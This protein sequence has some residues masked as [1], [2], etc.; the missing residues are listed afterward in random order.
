MEPSMRVNKPAPSLP[1]AALPLFLTVAL[2][3]WPAPAS[4]QVVRHAVP[5]TDSARLAAVL[6][7]LRRAIGATGASAAVIL[8]DGGV[9]S[10]ASGDAWPGA[11]A[12]PQTV[13]DVGSITKSYTAAL[14]L[15]LAADDKLRLDDSVARWLPDFSAPGVTIRHLLQHTSGI[16]DYAANPAFIPAIRA[17]IAAPWSP[18]DNLQF[19]GSTRTPPDSVWRYSNTNYV[20]LGI[21]AGKAGGGLY[22]QLLTRYVLDPLSLRETF[23]AGEDSITAERAH[24]F[25]DFSGDGKADD[26]SALVPDPA[27]TRG[28]GGAG[29]IVATAQDVARFA[30]A[31][32][33]GS[34]LGDA[35]HRD[36][37]RWRDRGDGW[38]YGLGVIGNPRSTDLLLGHLGNTTGVSAG[39][40][41]SRD[42]RITAVLL[43]NVHG[44]RMAAPALALLDAAV[45]VKR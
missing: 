5:A 21:I 4:P 24:A 44:V 43:A 35:V 23:V 7:S 39:V 12:T 42:R 9:W 38:Q 18:E 36:V 25:V 45:V 34:F 10:G 29:A 20:L 6:D 14:V 27:T 26:L 13:F 1:A 17:R 22:S 15:R 16:P 2:S 32:F 28:A 40:W 31:Y 33:T 8:P 11:V 30:R 19:A 41:H 3:L 37:V